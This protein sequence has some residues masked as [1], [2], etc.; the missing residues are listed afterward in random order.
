[1]A[2]ET[3]LLRDLEAQLWLLRQLQWLLLCT[4][5]KKKTPS[6]KFFLYRAVVRLTGRVDL[7]SSF[8]FPPS[9]EHESDKKRKKKMDWRTLGTSYALPVFWKK[10]MSPEVFFC[11][12]VCPYSVSACVCECSVFNDSSIA[13]VFCFRFPRHTL[14]S[15]LCA[16]KVCRD[17]FGPWLF[18][19]GMSEM[20]KLA[21]GLCFSASL[22]T[23]AV[24]ALG[25]S[26]VSTESLVPVLSVFFFFLC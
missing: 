11:R 17:V 10:E 16:P 3:F 2:D 24:I 12:T 6:T 4:E 7:P 21:R 18:D 23:S 1:M 15:Q 25:M 13:V 19:V 9:F 26:F 22:K 8:P 14:L 20:W 5:K